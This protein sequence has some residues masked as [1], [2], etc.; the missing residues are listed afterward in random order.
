MNNRITVASYI[1]IALASGSVNATEWVTTY[2]G[3]TTLGATGTITFDDWGFTGPGGRTAV[4]FDPINGFGGLAEGNTLDPT[5]GI[6]QIQ[7]VITTGPDGLTPDAPA[8]I[9]GDVGSANSYPN[10][11]VDSVATFYQWG[12]TSPAGSEFNNMLIDYDGDYH[13]AKDDMSF[14]FYNYFDYEQVG[15]TGGLADGTY[16]TKLAFQ[17]YALSDAQGWCGSIL[18][19]HP[20][21]DEAMAGQVT[22]DFA[23]DVYFQLAPGVYSYMST[24]IVS[25]FEM[26]SYGDINVDI[27]TE[28]GVQQLMSARAVV[29]NTDPTSNNDTVNADTPTGDPELWHNKVSFMGASVIPGYGAGTGDCGILTAEWAGGSQG[30]GVKKFD[31]I[32]S[33]VAD[34]AACTTA[35]GTWQEHAFSGFAFIL[36][37]DAERHIDYFDE[38][39]YGPDPMLAAVP[40]PAAAWL[41]GSGLLGLIGVARR[42]R[43]RN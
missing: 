34:A 5:G 7:H 13:I 18:A 26:R 21:A 8:D 30:P 37:A 12:Y 4:D 38:S 3:S 40:V 10:A 28:G 2:D 31:S 24:E 42:T 33:G 16:P 15:T 9:V 32:I 19:E 39:I 6:G 14:N 25:D 22:F 43:H 41:F 23:F 11:N 1:A 36:R 29:N 35:G 27:T 20:N 17:P